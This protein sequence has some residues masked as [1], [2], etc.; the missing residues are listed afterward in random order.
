[1]SFSIL[2]KSIVLSPQQAANAISS[3]VV[4]LKRKRWDRSADCAYCVWLMDEQ[5]VGLHERLTCPNNDTLCVVEH[6]GSGDGNWS[7]ASFR[8]LATCHEATLGFSLTTGFTLVHMP[9]GSLWME[10]AIR[11]TIGRSAHFGKGFYWIRLGFLRGFE[12]EAMDITYSLLE[13]AQLPDDIITIYDHPTHGHKFVK[14]TGK[15]PHAF[16]PDITLPIG[17]PVLR[18]SEDEQELS[19]F[20]LTNLTADQALTCF[21]KLQANLASR[22]VAGSK[23]DMTCRLIDWAELTKWIPLHYAGPWIVRL[24]CKAKSKYGAETLLQVVE[25]GAFVPLDLMGLK[26]SGLI[27]CDA[28][29]KADGWEFWFH[30]SEC[31]SRGK[32]QK[33][34]DELAK[35]SG[36]PKLFDR[37]QEFFNGGKLSY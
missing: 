9:K 2:G 15:I 7:R 31:G 25:P 20:G 10:G 33:L 16:H 18:F 12:A 23:L 13:A 6:P 35:F 21:E 26:G 28:L 36:V 14:S 11:L 34:R 8:A 3:L 37:N 19:D 4:G 29:R 22:P 5:L 30:D 17:L 24:N 32:R 27:V 1:M